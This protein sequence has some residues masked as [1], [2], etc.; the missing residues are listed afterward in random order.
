MIDMPL[1]K[2]AQKLLER[3]AARPENLMDPEPTRW[4]GIFRQAGHVFPEPRPR[5]VRFT[6][7][8]LE[9]GL[10]TVLDLGCGTG[11]HVIHMAGKACVSAGP[12][13]PPPP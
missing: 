10:H 4:E 2:I 3:A 7:L 5:V 11:R 13:T 8:L 6:E 1:L 12:T 9:L